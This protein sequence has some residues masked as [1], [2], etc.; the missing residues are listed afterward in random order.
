MK[1]F[2]YLVISVILFF[3]TLLEAQDSNAGIWSTGSA[4][5]LPQKRVELGLFQPLRYGY[6]DRVEWSVHPIWF[7]VMPNLDIKWSHG[8]YGNILITSRHSV[9]YPTLLLRLLSREGTGGIISPEFD[10]P[11]MVGFTNDI[12]FSHRLLNGRLVTAKLGLAFG[13]KSGKLDDR[14]TIDLPL[15]YYRLDY[16]YNG[17][18]LRGGIEWQ[19]RLYN[20]WNYLLDADYFYTLGAKHNKALE[21]KGLLIWN[22]SDNTQYSIGYK[23]IYSEYPFGSQWH[24]FVPI[25]DI[26]KAWNRD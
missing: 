7:F 24:L 3:S 20:R 13:F 6:S 26:Q 9:Y 12:L 19:G 21:H 8:Y 5:I 1:T 2:L 14:T 22:K 23:L 4:F 16:F 10:I 15:V 11:Q 17:F 18:Q 25:F